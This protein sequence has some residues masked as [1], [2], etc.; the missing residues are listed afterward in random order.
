M[1]GGFAIADFYVTLCRKKPQ[2][3]GSF[4]SLQGENRLIA[5]F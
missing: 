1:G 2:F 4:G 3:T 5:T